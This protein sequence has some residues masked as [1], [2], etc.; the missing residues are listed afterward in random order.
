M[1]AKHSNIDYLKVLQCI[2]AAT[3]LFVAAMV[4]YFPNYTKLRKLRQANHSVVSKA[5]VVGG[6]IKDLRYKY[7]KIGKDPYL[8][9]KI[10]RDELGVAKD[11]EIV[12][13]IKE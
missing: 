8:Y 11:N 4:F 10:A 5:R 13:D 7:R 3:V 12:V 1:R 2:F 6:E 9:E